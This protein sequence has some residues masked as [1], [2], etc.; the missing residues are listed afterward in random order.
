MSLNIPKGGQPAGASAESLLTIAPGESRRFVDAQVIGLK[1]RDFG[2]SDLPEFAGSRFIAFHAE[3]GRRIA[4]VRDIR[5]I[6]GVE[7]ALNLPEVLSLFIHRELMTSSRPDLRGARFAVK[8]IG[9]DDFR[10][11]RL[12]QGT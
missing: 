6:V 3:G 8:T 9:L 7:V 12:T 11:T 4:R 5:P 10:V 2:R 1:I